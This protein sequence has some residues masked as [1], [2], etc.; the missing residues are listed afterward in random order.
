MAGQHGTRH[1]LRAA[2][3]PEGR[4]QSPATAAGQ[5]QNAGGRCADPLLLLPLQ[6]HPSQRR[7]HPQPAAARPRQVGDFPA[8]QYPRR[9][10]RTAHRQATGTLPRAGRHLAA[11]AGRC[12]DEQPRHRHR[13]RTD[14]RR[15]LV[16]RPIQR[17]AVRRSAAADRACQPQQPRA[18][19]GV[20]GSE[21][22][23][24]A[25]PTKGYGSAGAG[26]SPARR[27]PPGAGDPAGLGQIQPEKVRCHS[28]SHR[29][30][31]AHTRY[32]TV[33]RCHAHRALGG[34]AAAGAEPAP[35][36]P[37]ASGRSTRADKSPQPARAGDDLRRRQ[38]CSEPDDPHGAGTRTGRGVHRRRLF[39]H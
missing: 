37:E 9:G 31:R 16:R 18:A 10:N 17:R 29:T 3:Q 25:R 22:C 38:R 39:R 36:L 8:V 34:A 13:R 24:P 15:P 12:A 21:R 32:P 28:G 4:G 7:A 30:R 2:R 14:Q 1:V 33:L 35:H 5:S 11:V 20:A 23:R 19:A 27:D 6:A 26:K